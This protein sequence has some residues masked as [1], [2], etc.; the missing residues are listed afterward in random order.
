MNDRQAYGFEVKVY[1]DGKPWLYCQPLD[2]E[3]HVFRNCILGFNFKEGTTVEQTQEI[4]N[5]LNN[6]ITHIF[7]NRV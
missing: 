1:S 5:L 2:K 7:Y 3:L 4:V 6:Y